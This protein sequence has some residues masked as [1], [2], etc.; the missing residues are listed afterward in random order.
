M[1]VTSLL[2]SSLFLTLSLHSQTLAMD[3]H[4]PVDLVDSSWFQLDTKS[5]ALSSEFASLPEHEYPESS[6]VGSFLPGIGQI[7]LD[8][9]VRGG[10]F[11]GGFLLAFPVGFGSGYLIGGALPPP[12]RS[13]NGSLLD[14]LNLN[15]SAGGILG[16]MLLPL[17]VYIWNVMDAYD[18]NVQK[19]KA[20]RQKRT[21]SLAADGSIHWTISQ[22]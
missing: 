6:W 20:I 7:I 3:V 12:P 15:A 1:K 8:E 21:L 13:N 4:S 11:M 2:L 5:L 14:G 16:A 10:L 17:G 9:P 19:N 22:F 18:L